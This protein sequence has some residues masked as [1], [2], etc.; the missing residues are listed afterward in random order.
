MS[1]A[2]TWKLWRIRLALFAARRARRG[3][4]GRAGIGAA[5]LAQVADQSPDGKRLVHAYLSGQDTEGDEGRLT[6]DLIDALAEDNRPLWA[7]GGFD[8]AGMRALCDSPQGVSLVRRLLPDAVAPPAVRPDSRR[9]TS[10]TGWSWLGLLGIAVTGIA[11]CAV[12]TVMIG[13]PAILCGLL[14]LFLVYFA[15]VH[16]LRP[17][18]GSGSILAVMTAAFIALLFLVAFSLGDWYL[19]ARGVQAEGTVASAVYQWTHGEHVGHC[20]VILPGGAIQRVAANSAD[21]LHSAGHRTPVVYD[22]HGRFPP[23]LG[24]RSAIDAPVAAVFAARPR[25]PGASRRR[26]SEASSRR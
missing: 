19:A 18:R 9:G 26:S 6:D 2:R 12:L 21:C 8:L 13:R 24:E 17:S 15:V 16:R 4:L 23:R 5:H 1:A 3:A 14:Y 10:R 22:P 20:R 25:R 11:L 7:E